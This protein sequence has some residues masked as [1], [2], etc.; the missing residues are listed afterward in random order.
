MVMDDATAGVD[1][2]FDAEAPARPSSDVVFAVVAVAQSAVTAAGLGAVNDTE[3]RV[4][5]EENERDD[6]SEGSKKKKEPV[7][8]GGVEL[9]NLDAC[10]VTNRRLQCDSGDTDEEEAPNREE[11]DV[12]VGAP[13]C[14]QTVGPSSSTASAQVLPVVP[15]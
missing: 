15:I 9:V 6:T 5:D 2:Q 7:F 10:D 3:A 8:L 1:L 13:S 12:D 11:M 14:V 4:H